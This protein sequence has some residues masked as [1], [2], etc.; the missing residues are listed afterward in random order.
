[1]R[2]ITLLIICLLG[3]SALQAQ[4]NMNRKIIGNWRV[5]GF[6]NNQQ[7]IPL[8]S[9]TGI[10]AALYQQAQAKAAKRGQSLDKMD[11]S[12]IEMQVG[13]IAR[14][15]STTIRFRLNQTYTLTIVNDQPRTSGSG[16]WSFNHPTQIVQ[17]N[18]VRNGK[19]ATPLFGK[20]W[21]ENNQ[22]FGQMNGLEKE[23]YILTRY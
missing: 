6:M 7:P 22:L 15:K 16:R 14:L 1:M 18:E 12:F 20:M 5:T 23:V 13:M 21:L 9:D 10:N 3:C 2:T 19:A 17:L 4:Q 11:S 8:D